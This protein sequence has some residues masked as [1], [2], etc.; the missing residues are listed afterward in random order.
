MSKAFRRR[1]AAA[2]RCV[3]SAVL[4][5]VF[6]SSVVFGVAPVTAFAGTDAST[7]DAAAS[8][9]TVVSQAG[10]EASPTV[11][12]EIESSR[13]ADSSK[14]LMSDG[15]FQT[16]ISPSDVN[17]KDADGTWEPIDTSLVPTD[18]FGVVHT[19]AS[20]YDAMFAS[21]DETITPATLSHDDWSISTR[22]LGG[23]QSDTFSMGIPSSTRSR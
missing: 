15:S 11:V 9:S 18:T 10:A 7:G 12:R 21:D 14:Y 2:A 8:A 16:M 23:E 22:L 20:A 1:G 6:A 19:K 3:L 5:G 13:T 4:A 17:Y